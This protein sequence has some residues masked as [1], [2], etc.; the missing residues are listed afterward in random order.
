VPITT[1]PSST[2]QSIAEIVNTDP[3]FTI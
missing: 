3:G 1:T 2:T